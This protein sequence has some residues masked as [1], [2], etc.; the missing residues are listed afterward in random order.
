MAEV[1]SFIKG[2]TFMSFYDLLFTFTLELLE[3]RIARKSARL[4]NNN[5]QL[6]KNYNLKIQI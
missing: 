4:P 5:C 2:I 6:S 3:N 1:Y